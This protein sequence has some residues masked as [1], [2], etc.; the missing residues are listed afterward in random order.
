MTMT[1]PWGDE[2]FI[3]SNAFAFLDV[4]DVGKCTTVSSLINTCAQQHFQQVPTT[5]QIAQHSSWDATTGKH[6][7]R[8]RWESS[9]D[10]NQGVIYLNGERPFA[11]L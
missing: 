8:P 7:S 10:G 1:T 6:V 11:Q 2:G 5:V 4:T 9:F 3:W